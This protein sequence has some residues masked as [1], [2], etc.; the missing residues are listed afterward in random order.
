[1]NDEADLADMSF[2]E[3]EK[4]RS[5]AK[6]AVLS[7]VAVVTILFVAGFIVASLHFSRP[8]AEK[9]EEG[10]EAVRTVEVVTV[11][12]SK[13]RVTIQS[14]GVVESQREVSLSAE[15]SG[16]L[17]EVSLNL[18]PG[19]KVKKDEILVVIDPADFRVA[20]E[21]AK[22]AA[23]RTALSVAQAELAIEEEEARRD[24]ALRD[25]KQLGKGEPSDLLARKPQ[26]VSARA[27]LASAKAEV[28]SAQE[29]VKRARQ[30]LERTV[31]RAP[32]DATVR[33]ESVE[34]GTVLTPG[35]AVATLF[36]ERSLEVELPLRLEDY[37]LLGR[38]EEGQVFGEVQ[39]TSRLGVREVTW[40]G[41]IV[42][43]SG[44]VERGALS[45][46]VVVAVDATDG[47]G[48]LRLPPPGLFVKASLQGQ[49]LTQALVVPRSAVREGDQVAIVSDDDR[50]E[51]RTLE[52]VRTNANEVIVGKGVAAGER[53][54]VTRLSGAV[55]GM[56]VE[57]AATEEGE[58]S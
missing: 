37:A 18:V 16:K 17:V 36:S 6:H 25:W 46:G 56:K 50:L 8:I 39:L 34:V 32:F 42:R 41:R 55:D 3:L 40:P 15:L 27:R 7:F 12:P 58:G 48:E 11:Q 9:K 53:V 35:T 4:E 26:L 20:L 1:M 24:Q 22:A 31:V 43:T 28:A 47:E 52:I 2:D 10:V 45:A 13:G 14:E 23:E 33:E 51:F 30:D 29:E 57:I 19:G 49:A 38:D 54:V 5:I 44:E 21:Q